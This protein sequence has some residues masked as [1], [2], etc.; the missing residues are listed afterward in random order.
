MTIYVSRY[1]VMY[2]TANMMMMPSSDARNKAFGVETSAGHESQ[3]SRGDVE[4][5]YPFPQDVSGELSAHG[6][7]WAGPR[8]GSEPVAVRSSDKNKYLKLCDDENEAADCHEPQA[9]NPEMISEALDGA[10]SFCPP[11]PFRVAKLLR[12]RISNSIRNE[13][14]PRQWLVRW[15]ELPEHFTTWQDEDDILKVDPSPLAYALSMGMTVWQEESLLT[16]KT[17]R[18]K[19]ENATR[20]AMRQKYHLRLAEQQWKLDR[21]RSQLASQKKMLRLTTRK[22]HV[23]LMRATKLLRDSRRANSLLRSEVRRV[24]ERL[25]LVE[26]EL[27]HQQQD[28]DQQTVE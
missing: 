18:A 16:A 19:W 20:V 3:Q 25:L 4:M 24:N 23:R 10:F 14:Q 5:I 7:P 1:F 22:A 8:Q 26:R 17:Q 27:L 12:L 21:S 13:G 15:K 9:S 28:E 11:F 2:T 6:Q